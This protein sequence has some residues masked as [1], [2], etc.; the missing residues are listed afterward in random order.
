MQSLFENTSEIVYRLIGS[1]FFLRF[2]IKSNE[3]ICLVA[4]FEASVAYWCDSLTPLKQ[5]FT[6]LTLMLLVANFSIT[7]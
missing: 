5:E 1:C 4:S 2:E 7:K 3:R 6:S